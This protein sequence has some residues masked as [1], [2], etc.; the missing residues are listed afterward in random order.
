MNKFVFSQTGHFY[1]IYLI[2]KKIR[3]LDHHR[4]IFTYKKK[5]CY[6]LCSLFYCRMGSHNLFN[7]VKNLLKT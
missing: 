1:I 6:L 2:G 4:G 3:S 5:K 7:N